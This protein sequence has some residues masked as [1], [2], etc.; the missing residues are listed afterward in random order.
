MRQTHY[1]SAVY[2][3]F[4]SLSD[5]VCLTSSERESQWIAQTVNTHMHLRAEP[6]SA[7]SQ[8]LRLLSPFLCGAPAAQ[9]CAR[10]VVLS[11]CQ[12]RSVK[13]GAIDLLKKQESKLLLFLN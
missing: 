1:R 7:S 5:V 10:A 3:Q 2:N 11:I 12:G 6:A 9:G 8:S 4:I 13:G